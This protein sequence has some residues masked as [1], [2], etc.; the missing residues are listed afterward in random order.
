LVD[1]A[2]SVAAGLGLAWMRM[3]GSWWVGRDAGLAGIHRT[4][5]VGRTPPD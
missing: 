5:I 2:G 4:F 1:A 3:A